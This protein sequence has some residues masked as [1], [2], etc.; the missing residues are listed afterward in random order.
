MNCALVGSRYFGALVCR[1]GHPHSSFPAPHEFFVYHGR[2]RA[3]AISRQLWQM[4]RSPKSVKSRPNRKLKAAIQP[5]RRNP[6]ARKHRWRQPPNPPNLLHRSHRRS[7][8]RYRNFR[9][10][11]S[12]DCHAGRKKLNKRPPLP[13]PRSEGQTAGEDNALERSELCSTGPRLPSCAGCSAARTRLRATM[14]ARAGLFHRSPVS[15]TRRRYSLP[16]RF[17]A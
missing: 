9:K 5:L 10:R 2:W 14:P 17:C 4:N 15:E 12:P 3:S 1:A 8:R 13:R 16:D 7:R 11:T 6:R